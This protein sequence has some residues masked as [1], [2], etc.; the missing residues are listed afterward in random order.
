MDFRISQCKIKKFLIYEQ[1]RGFPALRRISK[2]L[3]Q[4]R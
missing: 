1:T 4:T 3:L 2:K